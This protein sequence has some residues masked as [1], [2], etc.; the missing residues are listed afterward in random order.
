V[1]P[2]LSLAKIFGFESDTQSTGE[3][4]R[5]SLL[6]AAEDVDIGALRKDVRRQKRSDELSLS[7]LWGSGDDV[8]KLI[9]KHRAVSGT[10][11]SSGTPRRRGVVSPYIELTEEDVAE[12]L[13]LVQEFVNTGYELEK[14]IE[15]FVQSMSF[16]PAFV[17]ALLDGIDDCAELMCEECDTPMVVLRDLSPF[18]YVVRTQSI[19]IQRFF[20]KYGPTICRYHNINSPLH[21][22]A[23]RLLDVTKDYHT[24]VVKTSPPEVKAAL[25][26]YNFLMAVG[27]YVDDGDW[28]APPVCTPE[29]ILHHV[30]RILKQT[31]SHYRKLLKHQRDSMA[32]LAV[33]TSLPFVLLR[34]IEFSTFSMIPKSADYVRRRDRAAQLE[35]TKRKAKQMDELLKKSLGGI[36]EFPEVSMSKTSSAD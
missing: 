20:R 19:D 30:P 3:D 12:H 28:S 35:E 1:K 10:A 22:A 29:S 31:Q 24:H 21:L 17:L 5:T 23:R 32:L 11:M 34:Q 14:I 9:R 33:M 7:S 25:K 13:E 8:T 15:F 18:Q 26:T 36:L 2:S 27:Y 4:D 6:S 16:D